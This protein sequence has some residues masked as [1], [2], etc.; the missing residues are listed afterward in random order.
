M[1]LKLF[2]TFIAIAR[3]FR[4]QISRMTEVLSSD[5]PGVP[6]KNWTLFDFM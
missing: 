4:H 2:A 5:I 3:Q 6:P 1:V